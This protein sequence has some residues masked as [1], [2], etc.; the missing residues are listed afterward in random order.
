MKHEILCFIGA[1]L[2]SLGIAW[3]VD[4]CVERTRGNTV[5]YGSVWWDLGIET[6]DW[7]LEGMLFLMI[8]FCIMAVCYFFP[9]SVKGMILSS[10]CCGVLAVVALHARLLL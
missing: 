5:D 9:R 6:I 7:S 1:V 10:L 8:Y 3:I 4:W 2:G